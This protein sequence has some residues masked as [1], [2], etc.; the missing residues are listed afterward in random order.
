ML[1]RN[2]LV[3]ASRAERLLPEFTSM[4]TSASVWS[5]TRRPPLGSGTSRAWIAST[6]S[7]IPNAWK[8]G[9]PPAYRASF[10]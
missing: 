1:V 5:I 8:I 2:A 7:S 3:S 6:C 10:A 4:A 9:A